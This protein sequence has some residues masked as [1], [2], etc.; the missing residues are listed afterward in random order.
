MPN[1]KYKELMSMTENYVW[2]DGIP[3]PKVLFSSDTI[4]EVHETFMM[5]DEDIFMV[6]YPKSGK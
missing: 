1:R 3:F 2:L 5:R 4:R 6:T